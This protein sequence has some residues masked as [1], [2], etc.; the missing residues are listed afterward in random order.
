VGTGR[1]TLAEAFARILR[2]GGA[3]PRPALVHAL[4]ARTRE[5]LLTTARLYDDALPFLRELRSRGVKVAIVSNCDEN[6]RPLLAAAGVAALAD[7]LI[8]SCE[9]G[10]EKP[11]VAIYQ[12]ALDSLGVPAGAALFVDDNA[13][14]CAGA[15]ELGISALRIV[16]GQADG[17]PPGAAV[18]TSLTEVE[19][20]FSARK[21]SD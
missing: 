9:V 13:A 21:A 15:E 4:T 19:A 2:A 20:M 14:F 16:R 1:M 5:L 3:E 8:L 10:A 7:A 17:H 11:E 6:T 12:Q 18:V